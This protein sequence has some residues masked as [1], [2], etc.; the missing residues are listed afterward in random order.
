SQKHLINIINSL[1]SKHKNLE[2][3]SKFGYKDDTYKLSSSDINDIDSTCEEN[4]GTKTWGTKDDIEKQAILNTIKICYQSY[5][6][7]I[8]LDVKYINGDKH[9]IVKVNNTNFY[10]TETGF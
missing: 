3:D 1:I 2:G 4:F 10:K 6:K 8:G 5:F 9:F 7:S